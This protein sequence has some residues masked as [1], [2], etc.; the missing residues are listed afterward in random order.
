[1]QRWRLHARFA[2]KSFRLGLPMAQLSD[3]C[4]VGGGRLT[5]IETAL[6]DILPRLVPVSGEEEL[7]L[8]QTLGRILRRDLLWAGDREQSSA[9]ALAAGRRIVPQDIWL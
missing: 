6:S 5:G 4:F 1:M 3:D 7:P 8:Q 9:T 2:S